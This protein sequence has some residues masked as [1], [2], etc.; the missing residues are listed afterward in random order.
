MM[1]Q[2]LDQAA[3][4]AFAQDILGNVR[5]G[6]IAVAL[7]VGHETG[8]FDAM[9]RLVPST[10][11]QI[12]EAAGLQERYVREW[13][14]AMVTARIVAYDPAARTYRLPAEHAAVLT[15]AAGPG[16]L[17]RIARGLV[18]VPRAFAEVV[19]CFRSGGG[20]P[21]S[22]YPDF[23][24]G[25]AELS[26]EVHDARLID[27]ILPLMPGLPERLR[28]GID[29][30]D[31]GC[32][33]GHA[34]NLIARTFPAS[35]VTGYDFSEEGI[36]AA[37]SEAAAWGLANA[38]FE[39]RDVATLDAENAFEMITAFDAIHD[40]A[41]PRRVLANIARALRPGGWFLM[42]DIAAS[43]NLEENLDHPIAPALYTV[44]FMH[45]M[46]VSLAQGGEGLG[47]MWGGQKAREL[48]AE[49][50]FTDV[51]VTRVDGDIANT[52]Y[53]CRGG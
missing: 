4:G 20:V 52:Y 3:V 7:A 44:S 25:A 45:C 43:S 47:S 17:A 22:A 30:A 21:Y 23:Q 1:T 42:V 33:M 48:L 37:R 51:S 18:F 49:A 6:W 10:S 46:T 19:E 11:E 34:V 26:R 53:V 31:I 32:G 24:R 29:V 28:E 41:H 40:Q 12:A 16:N 8:L 50:G 13:L 2:E 14:A 15:R 39:L 9:A 36:A 27:T 35:R 5:G 38:R